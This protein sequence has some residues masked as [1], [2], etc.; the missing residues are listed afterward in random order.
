VPEK[1]FRTELF[2]GK[3]KKVTERL[4]N[5]MVLTKSCENR[6]ALFFDRPNG[7]AASL[8]SSERFL[9]SGLTDEIAPGDIR[10]MT[11]EELLGLWVK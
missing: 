2:S 8:C 3:I 4:L 6:Q 11:R 5:N 1:D 7:R 10:D 9:S